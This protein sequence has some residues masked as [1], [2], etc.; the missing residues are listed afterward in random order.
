MSINIKPT[1]GRVVYFNPNGMQLAAHFAAPEQGEPLA[2]IIVAV[3]PDG[4]LNLAMFD[5]TGQVFGQTGVRLVQEGEQTPMPGIGFAYWMPF[6]I[7]Q[8]KKAEHEQVEEPGPNRYDT[9]RLALMTPGLMGADVVLRAASAY[10]AYIAGVPTQT[11]TMKAYV[12]G[13]TFTGTAPLPEVSPDGALALPPHQQRVLEEHQELSAKIE[14]LRNFITLPGPGSFFEN[15]PED[16]RDRLRRQLPA[17]Q[18][19]A[20]ILAERIA[21]F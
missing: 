12:D 14:K 10:Q 1:V 6:Q 19:Y 3:Q 13:S 7:G 8:A 9:L 16:E 11:I 17:M 2:A 4:D 21:T 15:L 5:A 18:V 20:D